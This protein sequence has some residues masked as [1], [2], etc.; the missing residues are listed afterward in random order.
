[1]TACE[2]AKNHLK[3]NLSNIV[4]KNIEIASHL[5]IYPPVGTALEITTSTSG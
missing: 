4:G 5:K 3:L 1:M 2:T